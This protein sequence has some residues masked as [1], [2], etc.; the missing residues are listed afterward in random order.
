MNEGLLSVPP[1]R[2]R[3]MGQ[4][5]LI[6]VLAL[7]ALAAACRAAGET[8]NEPSDRTDAFIALRDRLDRLSR[9]IELFSEEQ[10]SRSAALELRAAQ[11]ESRQVSVEQAVGDVTDLHAEIA[12]VRAE[13]ARLGAEEELDRMYRERLER[14]ELV[15]DGKLAPADPGI[16]IDDIWSGYVEQRGEIQR[17]GTQLGTAKPKP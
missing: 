7:A 8:T 11:L 9:R 4:G 16:S 14:L 3:R 13:I 10:G 1:R 6:G 5:V 17:L 12:Q 2:A 15:L